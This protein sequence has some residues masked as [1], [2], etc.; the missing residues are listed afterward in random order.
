MDGRKA[1]GG[2]RTPHPAAACPDCADGAAPADGR[3]TAPRTLDAA[4]DYLMWDM[5][6]DVA[7]RGT[8]SATQALGRND[9]AGKTGTTNDHEDAWFNGFGPH[10][11]AI[12]WVG[13]DQ[14]KNLGYGEYG[15]KAALPIWM[16]YM[17]TALAGVPQQPPAIPA[18]VTQVKIDP[19]TGKQVNASFPNPMTEYVQS[20]HLPPTEDDTSKHARNPAE[21]LY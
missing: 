8:G 1:N 15:A 11:V 3:L 5:L 4:D 6:H 2:G 16:D 7:V 21:D 9:L 17:K 12:A 18:G 13:F 14:P 10:L 19:A 20:V